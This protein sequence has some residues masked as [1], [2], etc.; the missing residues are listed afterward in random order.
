LLGSP[1]LLVLDEPATGLDPAQRLQLRSLLS[2]HGQH[3]TVLLS[4]HHTVEVAA[5]CQ[6]V[7]VMLRG[8]IHFDG[9]P[10]ELAQLAA[11]RVWVD[12]DPSATSS[13]GWITA[14]GTVRAIGDPPPGAELVEP[15]I[16]DG[17]LLIANA[18]ARR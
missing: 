6:R 12:D 10:A 14:D 5:F 7:I 17:Y 1:D 3:G 9:A 4:T 18:G 11:G 2:E 15:T 13:G 8:R 16:D